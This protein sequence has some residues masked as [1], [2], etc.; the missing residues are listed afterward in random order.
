ME[1]IKLGLVGQVTPPEVERAE[2]LLHDIA[3]MLLRL[4][5]HGDV[6][7]L[8]VRALRLKRR[9]SNWTG[10]VPEPT[11]QGTMRELV[12]LHREARD[13]GRL[14]LAVR[15]ATSSLVP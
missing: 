10:Q 7:E 3:G 1:D 14:P 2:S 15:R 4:P 11:V 13:I 8:H 5:M 6:P 9:V 12:D